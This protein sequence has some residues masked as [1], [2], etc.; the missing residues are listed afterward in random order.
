[1]WTL[2][3]R[4]SLAL[5]LVLHMHPWGFY[6]LSPFRLCLQ[7]TSYLWEGSRVE[8]FT[9]SKYQVKIFIWG[10]C[11][12]SLALTFFGG[13][14]AALIGRKYRRQ[15]DGNIPG[16]NWLDGVVITDSSPGGPSP[17][18][19]HG[20]SCQPTPGHL[21]I[22]HCAQL[23]W[24][25]KSGKRGGHWKPGEEKVVVFLCSV[26]SSFPFSMSVHVVCPRTVGDTF[27]GSSCVFWTLW[28]RYTHQNVFHLFC[29]LSP[30][31]FPLFSSS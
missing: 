15:P 4:N 22:C 16:E 8:W 1:M 3:P 30:D 6:T 17:R 20:T 19:P 21:R 31:Y 9:F 5:F 13:T 14:R 29:F 10:W 18:P 24:S 26:W 7:V 2:S 28:K 27:S 11:S 23:V 25:G 12:I